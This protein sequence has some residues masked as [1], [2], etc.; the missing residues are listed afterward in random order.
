MAGWAHQ[1]LEGVDCAESV[2]R[3][4]EAAQVEQAG[5]LQRL[6]R[7]VDQLI[8]GQLERLQLWQRWEA[9]E[10]GEAAAV[11]RQHLQVD[12]FIE[13]GHFGALARVEDE[14]LHLLWRIGAN[15][16]RDALFQVHGVA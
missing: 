15:L 13:A 8:V 1:R 6:E 5:I 12:K 3:Q 16:G 9:L 14:L 2:A 11:E 7:A 10:R 4:A